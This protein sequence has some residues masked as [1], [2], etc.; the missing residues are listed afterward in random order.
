MKP[1]EKPA[2]AGMIL[3]SYRRIVEQGCGAQL[4]SPYS[5]ALKS[6][7]FI[8]ENDVTM[9][10]NVWWSLQ[11][12]WHWNKMLPIHIESLSFVLQLN[13]IRIH[14]DTNIVVSPG[15]CLVIGPLP[16]WN[17][18]TSRL[19]LFGSSVGFYKVLDKHGR[20]VLHFPFVS[21]VLSLWIEQWAMFMKITWINQ[22]QYLKTWTLDI[23]E[24][25]WSLIM[26]AKVGPNK[27]PGSAFSKR[28]PTKRSTSDTFLMK[29]MISRRPQ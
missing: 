20:I 4:L 13:W 24:T 7:K 15:I 5:Y 2:A 22:T 18:R 11:V 8:A 27:A 26:H 12:D 3:L 1:L 14:Q 6:K 10:D 9:F 23:F 19:L 29:V 16:Y 25:T 17:R 21:F 28:P